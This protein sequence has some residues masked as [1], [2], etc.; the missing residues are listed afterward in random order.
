MRE[1]THGVLRVAAGTSVR[2]VLGEVRLPTGSR[3]EIPCVVV[4]G[5]QKGPTVVVTAA[6]HGDEIVGIGAAIQFLRALNPATLRGTVIVLPVVNPPAVAAASYVSPMDGVNMCGPLYWGV[7]SGGSTS[8]QLG[9]LIGSV[10]T[11]ADFYIDLHGNSEPSA[12]MTM[13]FLEQARDERTR[14]ATIALAAAFGLTA[15]DMSAPPAHPKWLGDIDSYPVPTALRHGIPALMVELIGA[16][17]VADADRGRRGLL[18]VLQSLD[19]LDHDG[20][21]R[22]DPTRLPGSYR[23]WGALESEV[24]GVLWVRQPVGMPFEAGALLLEIT[25]VYGD[26][27]QEIRSPVDGFCWSYWGTLYGNGTHAVPVGATVALIAQCV[28]DGDGA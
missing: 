12:P 25:D 3:V 5:A 15:V 22:G 9:A 16:Q 7:K 14:N 21:D 13:M 4:N 8:H 6:A 20:S 24:A 17:T 23:Y 1:F 27:L 19:M 11:R 2:G 28:S 10:L 18:A 26:I